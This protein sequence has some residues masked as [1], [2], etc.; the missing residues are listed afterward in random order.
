MNQT[1]NALLERGIEI[2][3]VAHAGQVDMNGEAYILHPLRVMFAVRDN[4]GSI[5]E[6]I[7]AVL[8]DVLEDCDVTDDFL[9]Q[10]FPPGVC[11]IVDAVTHQDGEDYPAF[12]RRV[13]L[14]AGALLV[15]EMDILDNYGRLHLIQDA[16]TRWRL[17]SKYEHALAQIEKLR[18]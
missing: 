6:Q 4:G 5:E 15:K 10:R 2:A 12:L 18:G 1:A 13:A 11:D 7:A 14:T 17:T 9:E 16:E 3:V 8:H